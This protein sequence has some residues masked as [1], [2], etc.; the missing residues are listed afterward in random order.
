[1]VPLKNY[2]RRGFLNS[3][4]AGMAGLYATTSGLLNPMQLFGKNTGSDY[5]T[6]VAATFSDNYDQTVVKNKVEHLFES[7]GG[8][9]DIISPGDK[10]AIKINLTGGSDTVG[11]ENLQ[12]V[13]IR[14]AVWT[15][16]AVLQAVGELLID[17]GIS[18]E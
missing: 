3:I 10:V 13:D 1:M 8:I 2:S 6:Q 16:P 14:E 9:D 11:H 15:H 18:G 5:T 7:L 12:G 4:G 17:S